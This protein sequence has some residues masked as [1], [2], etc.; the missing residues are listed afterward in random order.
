[1]TEPQIESRPAQ[2]YLRIA[3]RIDGDV[4]SFVDGAFNALFEH[5]RQHGI[6]ATGPEFILFRKLDS[7]GRPLD[8]EVSVPVAAT[9][10]G[11]GEIT[12]AELPPGRYLTSMH[13]GPYHPETGP[14]LMDSLA[15]L[16]GWAA[17]NRIE[18]SEWFIERY[19]VGPE[20]ESDDT[21]WQTEFACLVT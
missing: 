2:P 19:L 4:S 12:A 21:N 17:Q 10:E 14:D 20:T 9:T 5:L 18:H 6:E 1:M 15:H 16:T 13:H 7:N 11:H 3:G 8:V